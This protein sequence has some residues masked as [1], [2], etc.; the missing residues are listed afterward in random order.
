M[1]LQLLFIDKQNH[2]F[3]HMLWVYVTN[4]HYYFLARI[5]CE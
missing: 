4:S 5:K 2:S 1:G 3:P